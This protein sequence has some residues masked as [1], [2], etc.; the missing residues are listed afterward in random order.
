M[1]RLARTGPPGGTAQ[2]FVTTGILAPDRRPHAEWACWATVHGLSDLATR[3]PLRDQDP[4]TVE[5]LAYYVVDR[6]ITG[7]IA[8]D[9]SAKTRTPNPDGTTPRPSG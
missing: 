6:A 5:Q 9:A 4:A 3:G 2:T 8:D 1:V 7:V